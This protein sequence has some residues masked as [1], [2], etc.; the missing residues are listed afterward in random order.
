[1][2]NNKFR[3]HQCG[4]CCGPVPCTNQELSALKLAIESMSKE[5]RERLKRKPYKYLTCI[6][7]DVENNH[8]SVYNHRPLVCRQYGQIRELKCPNNNI[9]NLKSGR[10]ETAQISKND[11]AGILSMNIGWKELEE[12]R[13]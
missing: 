9:R 7:L 13:V 3:C 1:M 8:C 11:I 4:G 5:E 6:L 10:K 2:S 12:G